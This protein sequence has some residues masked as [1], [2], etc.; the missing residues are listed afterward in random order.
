MKAIVYHRYGPPE[1]LETANVEKP[2]PKDDEILIRI[3]AAAI[4]TGDTE[5]RSPAI[6]NLIW[7]IVRLVFG[8]RKPRK[9]ILGGYLS[10]TVEAVGEKVKRFSEGDPIFGVSGVRFGAHAEYLCVPEN[11]AMVPKPDG[12]SHEEA[13]PVALGLDSLYFLQKSKLKSGERILIN[14]AGGGIGTYAVQLAKHYG[15]H[16]TAVDRSNKLDMLRSVGADEVVDFESTPLEDHTAT[17]DVVFDVVGKVS[18]RASTRLLN[19][20]GRYISAVLEF[21][22]M[23]PAIWTN[24]TSKKKVMTGL[25][26]PTVNDLAYLKELM[27]EGHLK[28]IIEKQYSLEEVPDAHRHIESGL[29]WGNVVLSFQLT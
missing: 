29:K 2:V 19:P 12:I 25:T 11:Y 21:S 9:K 4:T 13:A 28:T 16:V 24:L 23:I 17:Y 14:G 26:S 20:Q 6:P 18:R 3:H 7:F 1:V 15:A 22:R 27:E 5:L 10:G 8:L